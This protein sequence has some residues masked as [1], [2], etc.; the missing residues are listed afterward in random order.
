MPGRHLTDHHVRHYMNLR[1][2]DQPSVAAAKAGISTATAYRIES[3]PQLPSQKPT[4]RTRRRPDPL[5]GIFMQAAD[6]ARRDD[7]TLPSEPLPAGPPHVIRSAPASA[8]S[9]PGAGTCHRPDRP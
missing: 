3:D 2:K 7:V 4:V 1:T 6:Q 9:P 5:A 8:S